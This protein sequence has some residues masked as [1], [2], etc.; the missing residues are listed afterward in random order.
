MPC[1]TQER[2]SKLPATRYVIDAGAFY[3]GDLQPHIEAGVPQRLLG[4]RTPSPSRLRNQLVKRL[5][6][7]LFWSQSSLT[8]RL[9]P[10]GDLPE[11]RQKR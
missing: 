3:D 2:P 11:S 10:A 9:E 6:L 1:S 5:Q 8:A 4:N 7:T